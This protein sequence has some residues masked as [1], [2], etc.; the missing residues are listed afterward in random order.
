MGRSIVRSRFGSIILKGGGTVASLVLAP[1]VA[2]A[3]G[4][5]AD[6]YENYVPG[7]TTFYGQD[8]SQYQSLATA[9]QAALGP[10]DPDTGYGAITPFNPP[11]STSDIMVI[12]S[13]G[14]LTLHLSAAATSIGVYSNNGITDADQ[15][16]GS[17][18][19][20][21]PLSDSALFEPPS[22]AIVSV[23]S[24]GVHFTALN[25]GNPIVF[26]TPTNYWADGP[27]L[28]YDY[29]SPGTIPANQDQP[30][31][32]PTSGN[33]GTLSSLSGMSY[34]QMLT[35]FN[36]SAGGTWLDTGTP[37][38]YVEFSVP[39]DPSDDTRL[40]IDALGGVPAPEPVSMSFFASLGTGLLLR[41][42]RRA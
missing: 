39:S 28:S 12:G 37:V 21:D 17:G 5:T 40:V 42:R 20:P 14:S 19:A 33:Y 4:I 31:Y 35:T 27:A 36:G 1:C 30:W 7:A 6:S 8:Y 32:D 16:N 24:D 11:Y 26:D 13:G 34:D 18:L 22:E 9:P 23:S 3:A 25:G 2:H 38:N 29:Q 10:L 41:R 15:T